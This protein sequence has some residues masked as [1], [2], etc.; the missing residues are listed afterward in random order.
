MVG[1][2]SRHSVGPTDCRQLVEGPH[3]VGCSQNQGRKWQFRLASAI[4]ALVLGHP[5]G[6]GP[7]ELEAISGTNWETECLQSLH[8]VLANYTR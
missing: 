2:D 1:S 5:T 7:C 4:S 8:A 3:P 6:C